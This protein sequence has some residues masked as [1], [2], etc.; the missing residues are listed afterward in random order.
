LFENFNK[1][2]SREYRAWLH[3]LATL[4]RQ[5]VSLESFACEVALSLQ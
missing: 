1:D 2:S 5:A 4:A 3:S